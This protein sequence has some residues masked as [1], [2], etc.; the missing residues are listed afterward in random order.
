LIFNSSSDTT[1]LQKVVEK[2][3]VRFRQLETPD[4]DQPEITLHHVPLRNGET[5]L[6]WCITKSPPKDFF[7]ILL[8]PMQFRLGRCLVNRQP[9]VLIVL[10]DTLQRNVPSKINRRGDFW[11]IICVEAREKQK[12]LSEWEMLM[13]NQTRQYQVAKRRVY[14]LEE[15]VPNAHQTTCIS[16]PNFASRLAQRKSFAWDI[17]DIE[18]PI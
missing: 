4:L 17:I 18:R 11:A 15:N 10:K 13:F 3:K 12:N 2:S 5:C 16:G 6:A 14:L 7:D 8:E 1:E 9:L